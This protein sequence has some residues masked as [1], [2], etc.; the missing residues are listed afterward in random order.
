MNGLQV[1]LIVRLDRHEAH[2]LALDGFRDR[3]GIDK[4]VLVGRHKR[5]HE[6]SCDQPHIVALLPQDTAQEVSS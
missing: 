3:F 6:L 2:V 1:Q 5:L 4:I